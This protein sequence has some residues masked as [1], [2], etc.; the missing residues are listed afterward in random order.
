MEQ[1]IT[2]IRVKIGCKGSSKNNK[3]FSSRENVS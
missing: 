1:P 2:V 3:D